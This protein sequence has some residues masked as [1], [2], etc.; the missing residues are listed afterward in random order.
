MKRILSLFALLLFLTASLRAAAATADDTARFLAGLPCGSDSPL[1]QIESEKAW[2]DHA[3][4]FNGAWTNL[5]RRQLDPIARSSVLGEAASTTGPMFYMFS[6]PDF[7]YASAFFPHASTYILAGLEPTGPLP[8]VTKPDDRLPDELANLRKSLDALLN[9][10]FFRTKDMKIDL[11]QTRLSGTL[12]VLYVFL[13]RQNCRIQSVDFVTLDASGNIVPA[14][15]GAMGVRILFSGPGGKQTL[16]YFSTNLADGD[17]NPKF[18]SFCAKQGDGVSLLKAA[19]YLMHY[20]GFSTI[21]KFLLSHTKT[22]VQDD[23]GIP[24]KYFDQKTWRLRFEG[25]YT[26]PT[27]LFKERYQAD[28]MEVYSN[29]HPAPMT[30]GFGYQWRPKSSN[31]MVAE[32]LK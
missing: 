7:L 25:V 6:G 16:Y 19:S 30:F 2:R 5:Q 9:W 3:A 17:I 4:F 22:I 8:D 12:P 14:Q 29:S 27:A 20:D 31:L 24:L 21:R 18:L 32:R 23:S 26:G 15:E 11:K 13:A 10:S 1:R 28:L